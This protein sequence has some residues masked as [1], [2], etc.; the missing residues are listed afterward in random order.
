MGGE[1][2]NFF[3]LIPVRLH[4]ITPKTGEIRALIIQNNVQRDRSVRR[5]LASSNP[6]GFCTAFCSTLQLY[7]Q[8]LDLES[9]ILFVCGLYNKIVTNGTRL[10]A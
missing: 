8:L 10:F 9:T 1:V 6:F 3:N 5:K 7:M 2:Q 4:K